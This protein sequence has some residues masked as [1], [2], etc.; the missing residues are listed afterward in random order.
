MKNYAN[1]SE[2]YRLALR[3]GVLM[4]LCLVGFFFLMKAFGLEHNL[5]L[6]ALNIIILSSFVYAALKTYKKQNN[7]QLPYL[8]G[9]SIGVFT[10]AVGVVLFAALVFV[11][12]TFISPEFMV[13]I[14]N[15]EPFGEFLNPFIVSFTIVFEG[16]ISGL[17]VSFISLQ[18]LR[19]SHMSKPVEVMEN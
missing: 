15:Q 14:K 17:L 16:M 8:S 9:I 7:G 4:T 11:Y 3:F 1:I 18:Y 6:R 12:I 2:T 13:E 19:P 10:S 5:E